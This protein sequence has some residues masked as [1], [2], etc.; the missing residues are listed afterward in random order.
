MPR[1]FACVTGPVAG[2]SM[3][4][5]EKYDK[6]FREVLVF[7]KTSAPCRPLVPLLV[8]MLI[9]APVKWPSEAS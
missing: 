3:D 8:T 7:Q 1:I 5:F 6:A 4:N 2:L 9:W